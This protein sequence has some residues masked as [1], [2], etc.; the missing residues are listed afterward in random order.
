[1]DVLT[2]NDDDDD[3]RVCRENILKK[4]RFKLIKDNIDVFMIH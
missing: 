3:D 4:Y 2:I 1:M